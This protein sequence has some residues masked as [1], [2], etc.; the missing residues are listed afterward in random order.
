MDKVCSEPGCTRPAHSRGWCGTHYHQRRR[1][2]L[3]PPRLT[4]ADRLWA[5]VQRGEGCWPFTGARN[6]L[7]YGKLYVDGKYVPAHR[8]A[9][10]LVH[11]PIPEGNDL[12]HRC[13]NPPC[14]RPSHL[15]PVT[16][17]ENILV[18]SAPAALHARKTHCPKGHPYSGPNLR[19]DT[20]GAR[21]CRACESEH[22]R[23]RKP[24]R[25]R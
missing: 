8:V 7:G 17:R 9:F 23:N 6:P 4:V 10:E 22:N 20:N 5:K 1:N 24:R 19:I 16:H 21:R 2:G 14:C 13:E 11:G 3:L 18:G 15:R 12:H 25:N